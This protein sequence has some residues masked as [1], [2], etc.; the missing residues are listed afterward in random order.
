MQRDALGQ[1]TSLRWYLPILLMVNQMLRRHHR[2]W[3]TSR[4]YHLHK[5]DAVPRSSVSSPKTKTL[6]KL[7]QIY[8]R[9]AKR[10]SKWRGKYT[11]S[12]LKDDTL[13]GGLHLVTGCDK[14]SCNEQN[15]K[16]GKR[17]YKVCTRYGHIKT[18]TYHGDLITQRQHA[19]K[20]LEIQQF[21]VLKMA[22]LSHLSVI[23]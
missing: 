10:Y 4:I 13:I 18:T 19:E 7:F 1:E 11:E 23:C 3:G 21:Q 6:S 17:R 22:S 2:I 12:W 8:C 14:I 16:W 5:V 15:I 9:Q 20:L